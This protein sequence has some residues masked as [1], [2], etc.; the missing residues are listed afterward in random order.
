MNIKN[1]RICL[2]LAGLILIAGNLFSQNH[3]PEWRQRLKNY[4]IQPVLAVQAWSSYT[5]DEQVYNAEA[6]AYEP[7][8]NRFNAQIRRTRIG[9]K[10]QPGENFSFQVI[11]ALDL[12][13]RDAL[14]AHHGG[15]NNGSLP[16]FGLWNAWFQWRVLKGS[17]ALYLTGGYMPPQ[18]GRESITAALR[19]TSMEKAWSQRY[20]RGQLTG[21]NP[22]RATGVNLGGFFRKEQQPLAISYDLGLFNPVFESYSGNSS[23][24]RYAPLATGRV[25]LHLGDPE[26]KR[27]TMS[28]KIN[29][30]SERRGLTLSVQGATQ[31]ETD[32]FKAN[33][34]V[35]TDLLFNWGPVNLDAEW[36]WLRRDG[37]TLPNGVPERPFTATGQTGHV[38]LSYNINVANHYIVEPVVMLMQYRGATDAQGQKDAQL[39][40]MAAGREQAIDAGLN[41]YFDP[42][43][44]LML[45]YT[46]HSGEPGAAGDGATVNDFFYQKETGPIQRGDWLGLGLTIFF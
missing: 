42:N 6:E 44:V 10:A 25:S 8:D 32:L 41:W 7:V 13:G 35:G 26:F 12:V 14:T 27:Y 31:G 5:I 19:V 22:G 43:F 45:H 15:T 30:M 18:F 4:N 36:S 34:A 9:F 21:T 1:A 3:A 46:H 39:V 23:G 33:Y 16:Q 37:E 29:Y 20:V 24:A 17:E 2:L 28:R 38:R 11:A 40:R